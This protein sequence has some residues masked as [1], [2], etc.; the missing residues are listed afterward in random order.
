MPP[1]GSLRKAEH[2]PWTLMD[3]SSGV[4]AALYHKL[5]NFPSSGA[6]SR[7]GFARTHDNRIPYE[8]GCI[9]SVAGIADCDVAPAT[10]VGVVDRGGAGA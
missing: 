6:H 1:F 2:C 9:G 8:L 3:R 10:K 5:L 4:W 7:V